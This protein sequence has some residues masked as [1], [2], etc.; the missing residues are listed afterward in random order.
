MSRSVSASGR[1]AALTLILPLALT[2]PATLSAQSRSEPG[3]HD[4]PAPA[5]V[6]TA[7]LGRSLD[8]A[9]AGASILTGD[10][11]AE[12]IRPTIGETLSR[13]PGVSATSFGP[14]ASRPVLRGFQGDRVRVLTDGI[15]SFDVSNSSVDHPVA[16]NPLTAE[17]VEVLRGPA[18]LLFG[19]SAIG[20]VVN[21]LDRRI[22]RAVPDEPIHADLVATYGTAAEERALMAGIDAPLGN[23]FVLHADGSAH[24]SAD[25]RTGGHILSAP[26]RA[27]AAASANPETAALANLEGRLP[28]SAARGWDAA[29]GLAWVDGDTHVG[30]SIDRYDMLAGSPIRFTLEPGVEAEAIRLDIRQWR[31]DLRAE[32]GLQGSVFDQVKLRAG[33]ADYRHVE[34]DEDGAAGTR[35]DSE[36]AEARLELVQAKRGAWRGVIGAQGFTRTL[37][38]VGD[39]KFL[40]PNR[41]RQYGL[42][43]LQELD[44]GG[45]IAEAGL[46]LEHSRLSARADTDLGTADRQRSFD[47]VSASLGASHPVAPGWRIGVN[48]ARSA[49]A[50]TAEELFANGPHAGTQAFELG[51]PGF[52]AERSRG[53]ELTLNGKGRGY[54]LSFAAYYNR[55]ANYIYEAQVDRA[56]C[57][58]AANGREVDLPCFVRLQG[59]ATHYGFEAE[60]RIVIGRIGNFDVAADLLADHVHASIRGDGPAPYIPPLRLLGGIEASSTRLDA[61]IETEWVDR[62]RRL[63]R[64]ETPT[65]GYTS[66]NATLTWRPFP[67]EAHTSLLLSA[68]NLFDVT[69]RRHASV[70]KDYAPLAGRDIRVSLRLAL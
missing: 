12:T 43:T 25:L 60:G 69:A 3:F 10:A 51:N 23:G 63:A 9:L 67:D 22:P 2:L 15:G 11:L 41:S 6:V 17:R 13:Q 7:P 59:A 24:R 19:S 4:D 53:A 56:A 65:P 34:R 16:L 50:P 39:E 26:L 61:R 27:M 66:V 54:S 35:F 18:A 21:M 37:A 31:E 42:F 28:N 52:A 44:F 8:N 29:T 49:R 64:F 47:T 48:L 70:L 45:L 33:H 32:I 36:S 30:F 5:I 38:I 40:P 55:F 20:G 14:N 46:R 68:D 1:I 57:L 58:A 62:A